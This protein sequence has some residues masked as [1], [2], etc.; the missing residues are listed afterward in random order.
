[1]KN[2]KKLNNIIRLEQVESS[3]SELENNGFRTGWSGGFKVVK[4]CYNE[5]IICFAIL[6][7][8]GLQS[9]VFWKSELENQN[10]SKYGFSRSYRNVPLDLDILG[11][12]KDKKILYIKIDN[13]YGTIEKIR[14]KK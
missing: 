8:N 9:D 13:L 12:S 6:H 2:E 4:Y 7:Q 3:I 14:I 11:I 5:E 10:S 1:M